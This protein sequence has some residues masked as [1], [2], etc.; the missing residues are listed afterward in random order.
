M[1]ARYLLL[2]L[3][4]IA[5]P[6]TSQQSPVGLLIVAHGADSGWNARVRETVTQ[7]KWP[8]GPTALA[9]LMGAEAGTA[10]WDSAL[11]QLARGG[12]TSIRVVP[13]LVSSHGGHYRQIEFYAGLRGSWD[14]A[15]TRHDHPVRRPTVPVRVTPALDAAPEL[16]A[17]LAGGWATFTDADRRRPLVLIAHGPTADKEAQRWIANLSASAL[18]A[19]RRTGL[20]ADARVGLLRDDAPAPERAQAVDAIRDTIQRL[21][22]A[23]GDSVV[24]LTALISSGAIDRVKIPRDLEGLPVRYRPMSLTP[25]PEIA[26]W[27]ERIAAEQLTPSP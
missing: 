1:V 8:H 2:A 14:G 27:I 9:F 4:L 11:A 18:T 22:T 23:S 20:L 21:A 24:V 7:V 13:L 3:L 15:G 19:L 12:A 5:G 10:G 6:A 25:R 16:G 26:R 17:A